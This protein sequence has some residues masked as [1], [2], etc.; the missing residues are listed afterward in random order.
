M[1]TK[2]KRGEVVAKE[3]SSEIII[4]KWKNKRNVLVLSKKNSSEMVNIKT[5]R[6]FCCKPKM[7][8]EYNIGKTAID[9]SDKRSA[10]CCP[11]RKTIRWYRQLVFELFL[12][13][14]L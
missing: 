3:N 5:K 7:V 11:L 9:L 12:M 8:V 6:W 14:L 2:L 10:Y 13:Q 4:L 1:T